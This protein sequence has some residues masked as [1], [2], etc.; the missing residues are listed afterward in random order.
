MNRVRLSLCMSLLLGAIGPAFAD[1]TDQRLVDLFAQLKVAPDQSRSAPLVQQI[2]EIWG[3]SGKPEV[4]SA[5]LQGT[6]ALAND[7]E[8]QAVAAFSRVIELAPDFA[9]GWNKR[10]TAL[11]M[12]G[13]FVESE[14]DIA[15][16]LALE[17]R[18]FGALAG[19]G[20]CEASRNRM[21]QALAA[22][23]QA[24]AINPNMPGVRS[25]IERLQAELSRHAI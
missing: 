12:Q 5:L 9:E 8:D 24:L 25:R 10:A 15:H 18:H 2:W 22:F 13:R 6:R 4:D 23:Q 14:A 3:Q 1:Q 19:L 16:V 17:P 11:F 21:A 20:M 7:D